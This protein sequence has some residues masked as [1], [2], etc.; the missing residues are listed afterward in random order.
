MKIPTI[1]AVMVLGAASMMAQAA[2]PGTAAAPDASKPT[3]HAACKHEM[4]KT[5][6]KKACHCMKNKYGKMACP[7]MKKEAET[8]S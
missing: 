8:K 7:H 3:E 6:T 4:A 5:G 1:V 2:A